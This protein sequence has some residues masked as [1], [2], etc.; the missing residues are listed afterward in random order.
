MT[1]E[2]H[3]I[4]GGL[5]SAVAEVITEAYPVPLLAVGVRDHFGKVS[6]LPLLLKNFK[7]M[8]EDIV[9]QALACLDLK[10]RLRS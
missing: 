3:N 8:P 5:R 4:I 2:N 6:K 1:C 10:S 9:E 7:M